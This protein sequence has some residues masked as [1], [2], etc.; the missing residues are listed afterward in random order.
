M[1]NNRLRSLDIFRGATA[2][3]MIGVNNPGSW[4]QLSPPLAHAP[5]HGC[6][7]TGLVFPFFLFAVGNALAL[8][9]PGLQA[10]PS[11]VFWRRVAQRTLLIFGIGLFLNAS[12]FVRWDAARELALRDWSAL[13]LMGV[14]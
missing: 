13:R 4:S 7:P 1:L 2:T 8:V 3:L 6:T 11:S 5:W 14:L 9:M 10:Y 12:P